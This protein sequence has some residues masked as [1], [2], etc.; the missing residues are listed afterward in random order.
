M[1]SISAEPSSDLKIELGHVLFIDI[2][3]YSKLLINEQSEQLQTLK[4]IARGLS[5]SVLPRPTAN[6]CGRRR[7]GVGDATEKP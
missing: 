1:N 4:Q 2:V 5:S 7:E 6:F 3:G